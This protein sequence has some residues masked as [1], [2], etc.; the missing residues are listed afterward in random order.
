MFSFGGQG[1]EG[2][3]LFFAV[4]CW[5]AGQWLGTIVAVKIKN[6]YDKKGPVKD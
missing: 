1:R 6:I 4:L 2:W 5:A 3:H